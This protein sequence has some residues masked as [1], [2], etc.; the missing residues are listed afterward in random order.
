VGG[1]AKQGPRKDTAQ[2]QTRTQYQQQAKTLNQQAAKAAA[3]AGLGALG[4]HTSSS[5]AS[6]AVT[7][8]SSNGGRG[9]GGGSRPGS[10]AA[11]GAAE[12]AEGRSSR[13]SSAGGRASSAGGAAAAAAAAAA[14][15]E[16][17]SR[18]GSAAGAAG[19]SRI[20]MSQS[21]ASSAAAAGKAAG[22]CVQCSSGPD[23]NL[24]LVN[25]PDWGVAS[26]GGPRVVPQAVDVVKPSD[27]RLQEECEQLSGRGVPGGGVRLQHGAG[28]GGTVPQVIG[29]VNLSDRQEKCEQLAGVWDEAPKTGC[30]W[31]YASG[32]KCGEAE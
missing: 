15:G 14:A 31:G 18:S 22:G 13:L 16:G 17:Q 4:G 12:G 1:G 6:S 20:N 29:M 28:R 19:P 3:G 21:G 8:S 2:Q 9:V 30:T 27:R 23:I 11:G 5:R 26:G 25:A 32:D 10:V 24:L 7:Q